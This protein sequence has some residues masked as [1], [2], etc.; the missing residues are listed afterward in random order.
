[1]VS[2]A[3]EGIPA[4]NRTEVGTHPGYLRMVDRC[5]S[6]RENAMEELMQAIESSRPPVATASSYP[7][8]AG[9]KARSARLAWASIALASVW[10]A[11]TPAFGQSAAPDGAG[12]LVGRWL[13]DNGNRAVE[14][15]RRGEA[16]WRTV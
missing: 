10:L 15:A 7:G 9:G 2:G 16:F 3:A 12:G 1:F 6:T 13:T 11:M 5:P 14:S 8:R 4:D